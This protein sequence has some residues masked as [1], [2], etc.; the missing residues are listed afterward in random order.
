MA[1]PTLRHCGHH[2]SQRDDNPE[3]THAGLTQLAWQIRAG[4]L[5]L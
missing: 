4:K 2:H 5:R 3:L 1:A